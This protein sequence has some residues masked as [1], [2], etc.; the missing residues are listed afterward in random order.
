MECNFWLGPFLKQHQNP[1]FGSSPV[2]QDLSMHHD[3]PVKKAM[4]NLPV[5]LKGNLKC[6][7]G[8]LL[9]PLGPRTKILVLLPRRYYPVLAYSTFAAQATCRYLRASAV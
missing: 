9:S 3:W 5:R 1:F 6:I 7:S 4:V 8:N 2:Y